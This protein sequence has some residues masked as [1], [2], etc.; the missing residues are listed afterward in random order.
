MSKEITKLYEEDITGLL[1]DLLERIEKI[2][3]V[4]EDDHY[5]DDLLEELDTAL[6]HA[7]LAHG[8]SRNY[9]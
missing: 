3:G 9:N 4:P 5:W 2:T 1:V 8:R 7:S 6:N